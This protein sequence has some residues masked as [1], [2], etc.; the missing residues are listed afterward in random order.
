MSDIPKCYL[1]NVLYIPRFMITIWRS[2]LC[3]T[4]HS[5][6]IAF[7]V[8]Y[9]KID[10]L[11]NELLEC[12]CTLQRPIVHWI[13]LYM[14]RCLYDSSRWYMAVKNVLLVPHSLIVN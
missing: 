10:A 11:S 9:H 7:D 8:S 4:L 1:G 12:P 13:R 5:T 3:T 6:Y 14:R 2:V